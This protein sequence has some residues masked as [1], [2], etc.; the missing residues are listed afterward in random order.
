LG[1]ANSVCLMFYRTGIA[2]LLAVTASFLG[3]AQ[4]TA[5]GGKEIVDR[6]L[7]ALGGDKFLNMRYRVASG[8]I[9]SFFHDQLS[10]LDRAKIYTEYLDTEPKDGVAI[11]ERQLLGKK[12]DYS[13]LFLQKE[14]WDITFRGARAI[15]DEQ[16]QRYVRTTRNDILYILKVR[17]NEPG[18]TFDYVGSDVYLS[19]HVEIVDITDSQDQTIRVYFDHNTLYPI[20]ETFSWLDPVTRSRNDAVAEFNKYRDIGGGVMWPFTI[21][22]SRNGY[23]SFQMFAENMEA[24]GEVPP[25]MFDLPPGAKLLQKK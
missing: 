2:I 10:G 23:K 1:S 25:K 16:W 8:R 18:M 19:T 15:E 7:A 13:L 14:G 5:K 17:H 9:Y 3:T 4:N 12:G 24:N 11:R 20:R 21:E 6:S 22:R